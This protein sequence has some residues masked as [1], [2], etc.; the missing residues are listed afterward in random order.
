[1]VQRWDVDVL[2][3]RVVTVAVEA[4]SRDEALEQAADWKVIGDERPG[5]TYAVSPICATPVDHE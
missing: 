3:T 5:D 2:V 4:S 1:M